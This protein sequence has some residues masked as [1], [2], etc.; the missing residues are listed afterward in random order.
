VSGRQ[1]NAF[2]ES[3]RRAFAAEDVAVIA[4]HFGFPCHVTSESEVVEVAVT[5]RCM[6]QPA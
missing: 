5:G 6:M 4:D 1:A 3:Y 2:F